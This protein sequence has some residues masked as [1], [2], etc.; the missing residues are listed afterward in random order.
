MGCCQGRDDKPKSFH[1]PKLTRKVNE[2]LNDTQTQNFIISPQKL[3][4]IP[5]PASDRAL[6]KRIEALQELK[7]WE[8]LV[9]MITDKTEIQDATC[10]LAWAEKPKTVGSYV[11]VY[12]CKI[13]QSSPSEITPYLERVL[14]TIVNF[15]KTGSEDLRDHSLLLLYY[16]LDDSTDDNIQTLVSLNIFPILMRSIM[17]SKQQLR[18]LTA[19]IC[20]RLYKNRPELRELFIDIKGGKQLVQQISW[21]S[22][23]EEVLAT[24]L[25]YLIELLQDENN[26]IFQ[27]NI[28]RLNEEQAKDIIRDIN[29]SNKS[30][31]TLEIMDRVIT[32]LTFQE[33]KQ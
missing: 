15:I 11:L 16:F 17:C 20:Y 12:L 24:L 13:L 21:S 7:Q 30:P 32:L 19:G 9:S 3:P 27:E 26:I 4:D 25:E 31:E 14:P 33:T 23:N 22:E 18:H 10:K 8:T 1:T 28:D 29:T 5:S 6:K 2:E